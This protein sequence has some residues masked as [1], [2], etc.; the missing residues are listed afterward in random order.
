[1]LA[2][3]TDLDPRE[4]VEALAH[5]GLHDPDL[6]YEP[7][8]FGSH[9][10]RARNGD[11]SCA[12]VT[13]DALEGGDVEASFAAL[14]R[15]YRTAGAL[16]DRGGLEFVLAPLPDDEGTRCRRIGERYALS[17]TPIVDGSA[18]S[19]G[20]YET[21]EERRRVARLLGRLHAAAE[22][23]PAE[24]PRRDDLTI[25]DRSI[26]E[27][28]LVEVARPWETGPF[29]E[30]TRALLSAKADELE[31]RLRSH[32]ARAHGLRD[33][34]RSWVVTHGEPHRGNLI[35]DARGGL[36]LVDWDTTLVAPRERDLWWL[37]DDDLN[38]AEEYTQL[39]GD[40]QLDGDALDFYRQ[41]W[42][43]ADIASFVALFRRPHEE[44]ENATASF[45][46]LRAHLSR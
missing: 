22:V 15:A 3:P 12:W 43:L 5:W 32:D 29:A 14:D 33:R 11:G 19:F 16:R 25:P 2:P 17:V 24:L 37:L 41:R 45:G 26:V 10:W 1:M 4:I 27:D 8:G 30:P 20:A 39:A 28:A 42:D 35:A 7:V 6:D 44:D 34:S 18:G 9:H 13:V 36:H 23:V 38:G 21:K 40:A 46:Y 31:Q